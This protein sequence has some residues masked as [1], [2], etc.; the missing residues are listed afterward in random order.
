MLDECPIFV[1]RKGNIQLFS[2][3]HNYWTSPGNRLSKWFARNEQKTDRGLSCL[4]SHCVPRM[5]KQ[6]Y[7]LR[8]SSGLEVWKSS[9]IRNG[10][11]LGT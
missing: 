8:Y 9:S 6:Q 3:I 7:G 10:S 5:L 4:N 1:F 11:N 2:G